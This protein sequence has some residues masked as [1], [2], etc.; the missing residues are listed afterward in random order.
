MPAAASEADLALGAALASLEVLAVNAY[1]AV[2]AATNAGNL[3]EVPPAVDGYVTTA[4]AHHQAALEAWN[5]VLVTAGRPAVTVPP[6]DLTVTFNEVLG[7]LTDLTR[8]VTVL[9]SLETT[10]AATYLYAIGALQ[11]TSTISLA[12]S[13]HPV[14]RQHMTVLLFLAG[15]YPAPETFATVQFAYAPAGG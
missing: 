12:G 2:R 8:I 1:T 14:D 4:L 11:S 7:T 10:A 15:T 13:I 6:L 5:N 3:R 9:L